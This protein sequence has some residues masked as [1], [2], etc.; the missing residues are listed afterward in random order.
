MFS[1]KFTIQYFLAS[2]Q[3]ISDWI[4]YNIWLNGWAMD[5][6]SFT[7]ILPRIEQNNA[8]WNCLGID[9]DQCIVPQRNR[10]HFI[11]RRDSRL[12]MVEVTQL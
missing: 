2:D 10:Q 12:Q 8:R 6:I 5:F 7:I 4:Q 11:C 1:G 9:Y 3:Y